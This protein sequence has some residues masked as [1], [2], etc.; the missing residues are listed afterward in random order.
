MSVKAGLH[1][2]VLVVGVEKVYFPEFKE[3]MFEGFMAGTDIEVIRPIV[4][5]FK[6]DAAA[7]A[8]NGGG[9]LG[10]AEASMCINILEKV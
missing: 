10:M 5:A 2:M 7:L 4:E 8:E 6:A 9:F 3:I 1:D